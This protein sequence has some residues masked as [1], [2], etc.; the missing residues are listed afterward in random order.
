MNRY[1][2]T[3]A[4]ALSGLSTAAMAEP[5][6]KVR[7][8]TD[9]GSFV[10]QVET[11]RAPLTG[12]DF[13]RNVDNRKFDGGWFYRVVNPA[14][15]PGTPKLSVLQGGVAVLDNTVFPPLAHETTKETGLRHV[16]GTLSVAREAVGSGRT[17]QFFITMAASPTLDYGGSQRADGQ[18]FAAFARVIHGMD[19]V[20]RIWSSPLDPE[21]TGMGAKGQMLRPP[22]AIIRMR[23]M[24][25]IN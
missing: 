24:I 16:V 21:R 2:W 5:L 3:C 25:E 10:V 4:A 22:I 13:L 17:A 9:L 6:P 7:V 1:A 19:V 20:R 23:R 12:T 8:E 14:N 18:G 15:D 11:R